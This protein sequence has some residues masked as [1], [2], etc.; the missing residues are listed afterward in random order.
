MADGATRE[1]NITTPD[2]RAF[3]DI[4]GSEDGVLIFSLGRNGRMDIAECKECARYMVD[5]W[6]VE[7]QEKRK[8]LGLED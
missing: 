7:N 6:T 4:C 3:C 8:Q 5:Y 2:Y 1:L